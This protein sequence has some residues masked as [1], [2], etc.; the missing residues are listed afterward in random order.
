MLSDG[1]KT[2]R[3]FFRTGEWDDPG[4][5]QMSSYMRTPK[6]LRY[7]YYLWVKYVRR[8][9]I[10]A[11]LLEHCHAKSA[12][13]QWQW[14]A[15]REAYKARWH[16][17]WNSEAKMDFLLTP[18]NATPAVPHDGM[19]DAVSNCGYTFLFNLVCRPV[20]VIQ[21]KAANTHKLDYSC[22]IIPVT[23]VDRQLD[24]LSTGFQY[25]DLN[26]VAQ[27]AYK[28]YDADKMHGLPVAIQVVGQRLQEEK[29]LAIMQRVEDAL[30]KHGEKYELL[31]IQ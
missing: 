23:H 31:E 5:A 22:G 30:Q 17:W 1:S 21:W 29:V 6:P 25:K 16:E 27:G 8:D 7:L 18:P 14:V 4:A 28:Y 10:W 20:F 2:F 19:K 15:K 26:G 24:Q 9:H 3:S 11:G 13:Q 12:F